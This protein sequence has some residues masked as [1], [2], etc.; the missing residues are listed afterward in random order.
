L[1][2]CTSQGCKYIDCGKV[3]CPFE[4][5][6]VKKACIQADSKGATLGPNQGEEQED[7]VEVDISQLPKKERNKILLRREREA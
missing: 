1:I 2:K 7:E 4:E 3:F 5:E 6:D